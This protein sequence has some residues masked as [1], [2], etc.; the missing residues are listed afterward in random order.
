MNKENLVELIPIEKYF[1]YGSLQGDEY[2]N[3]IAFTGADNIHLNDGLIKEAMYYLYKRHPLFR[4]HIHVD[5]TS[6]KIYFAIPTD[7]EK[8]VDDM[9]FQRCQ[10]SS[11]ADVIHELERFNVQTFDYENKCLLWRLEVIEYVE[12]NVKMQVFA[13]VVPMY[14]TDGI[15]IAVL[16]IELVNILNSLL[17][18]Q[19]CNEMI[20]KLEFI[21]NMQQLAEKHQL[22]TDVEKENFEKYRKNELD[23]FF[24]IP[25][26]L[27]N[28]A[29]SGFKMNLLTLDV[30]LTKSLISFAKLNKIKLTG[31]LTTATFYAFK[32]LFEENKISMQKDVSVF[33]P[34][35]LRFR[36]EPKI[37][38]SHTRICVLGCYLNLF[39]PNFGKYENMIE[40]SKYVDKI[41]ADKIKDRSIFDFFIDD[42]YEAMSALYEQ[43]DLNSIYC[44]FDSQRNCDLII[45]NT[46]TYAA[47]QKKVLDGPLKIDELYYGDSLKSYPTQHVP[48]IVHVHTFNG[49]LMIQLS[50]NKKKLNSVYADRFMVLF[51]KYLKSSFSK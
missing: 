20:E 29:D 14:M 49:R 46:G 25:N 45:S 8:I 42:K 11:R 19:K 27:M 12:D 24:N 44:L 1:Y 6:G 38:F 15:N 4:A 13:L 9:K 21:E 10:L 32:D 47:D 5:S 37:D 35:N 34:V 30:E 28:I 18:N 7:Y 39:Y 36:V 22:I 51:E 41:L 16:C 31:L 2:V 43:M 48:L 50:S 40:E 26:K 3:G 23:V 17:Q 33:V